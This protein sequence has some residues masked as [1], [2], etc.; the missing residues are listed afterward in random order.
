MK[1]D[2]Y[3][4]MAENVAKVWSNITVEASRWGKKLGRNY[5]EV[6]LDG[7][8][9][10]ANHTAYLSTWQRIFHWLG[11]KGELLGALEQEHA[12]VSA[13]LERLLRSKVGMQRHKSSYHKW[14]AKPSDWREMALSP[15]LPGLAAGMRH[16]GYEQP[17]DML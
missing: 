7:D 13:L 4:M 11:C 6:R 2:Q 1:G 14:R 15:W 17:S 8:L 12:S 9:I 5:V 3:G 10:F 16:F